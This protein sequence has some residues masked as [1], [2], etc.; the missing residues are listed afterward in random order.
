M[1]CQNPHPADD[2]SFATSALRL[3]CELLSDRVTISGTTAGD[4]L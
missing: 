1:T 3:A 2:L 4:I